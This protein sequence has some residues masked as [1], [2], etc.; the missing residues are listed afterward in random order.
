MGKTSREP[1]PARSRSPRGSGSQIGRN[2]PDIFRTQAREA[3]ASNRA[4]SNAARSSSLSPSGRSHTQSQPPA[5]A[6]CT[7]QPLSMQDLRSVAEDIKATFFAAIT[8]LRRD[9]QVMTVRLDD[10]EETTTRHDTSIQHLQ[11][12]SQAQ[13]SQL[14]D[15]QRH[16]EDLD[17]RGR[18]HNIRVRG[19]PESVENAQITKAT[20]AIFN[21]LLG[22]PPE[23]PIE[24]ER[25]H[26]ALRPRGRESDPPRD[27]ICC[28][29][30][31]QLKEEILHRARD[32]HSLLYQ[33]AEIKLFQDLSPIT[34]QNRRDLR[35]L[36]DLLRTKGIQYRWKFPFCLSASFQGR[37]ANLRLPEDLPGF[38]EALNLPRI[39]ISDWYTTL[40]PPRMRRSA[41]TDA[42]P[43]RD[44]FHIRRRRHTPPREP[45]M[46]GTRNAP[47]NSPTASP[48]HRRARHD[49]SN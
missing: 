23:T 41:S 30:N 26:R 22:R 21:D 4:Y 27:V 6:A 44:D 3:P 2:I 12:S 31:F 33:G 29:I 43:V 18:R 46:S 36:L 7:P 14:R 40:R 32:R 24:F 19:I 17:N 35:P 48:A 38:C 28:L 13:S 9:V 34:L 42:I 49:R 45:T 37:T 15:I 25:L 11:T 20:I 1:S 5:A 47:L 10:L 39:D 16:M 8:D